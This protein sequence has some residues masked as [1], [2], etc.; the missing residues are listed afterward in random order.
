MKTLFVLL[1]MSLFV[2]QGFAQTTG[3]TTKPEQIVVNVDDLTTDQLAKIKTQNELKSMAEKVETYGKW[4]GVGNEVG[5]AIREGLMAVV[6]VSERFGETKVGEFTMMLIAWKI[7]GRELVAVILGILILIAVTIL[8]FKGFRNLHPRKVLI[9]GN[10]LLFWQP[11]E[12]E[13]IPAPDYEGIGLVK[14]IH[15]L[16]LIGAY[17]VIYAIMFA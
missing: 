16:L 9:K 7:M 12:Y 17:G 2:L 5:V 15:I 6:D 8:L 4:V 1:I 11:K 14:V 3:T 13:I 10:R